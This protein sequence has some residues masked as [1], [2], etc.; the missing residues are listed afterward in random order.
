MV[1]FC[2]LLRVDFAGR[3]VFATFHG[4]DVVFPLGL[5]Q[6]SIFPMMTK[7]LDKIICV[8][9]ATQDACCA[10]NIP[11]EKITVVHNGV[12]VHW[13][14]KSSEDKDS[15]FKKYNLD[16]THDKI[17]LTLGRPVKRKGFSG[18][19]NEVMPL[20][21]DH[22]K[23]VHIGHI[24]TLPTTSLQALIP[25]SWQNKFNLFMGKAD[26]STALLAAH[27]KNPDKII[28]AGRLA[29]ADRDS[30]IACAT[31]VVMPNEW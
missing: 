19:A 17:I 18:F 16:L 21:D 9:R 13:K 27:D 24:A 26:D 30:L 6:K 4:L 20:L 28:L 3:K 12:D 2:C 29:D 23:M 31:M 14:N 11:K 10:R 22:I 5:Y 7:K 1:A 8:S 25:K 15:A